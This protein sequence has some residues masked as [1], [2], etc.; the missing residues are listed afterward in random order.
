MFFFCANY[1]EKRELLRYYVGQ[2]TVLWGSVGLPHLNKMRFLLSRSIQRQKIE[3]K[4][5]V[6]KSPHLTVYPIFIPENLF[7][8]NPL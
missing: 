6:R 8:N 7:K 4:V 5:D 1:D 2:W 3:T